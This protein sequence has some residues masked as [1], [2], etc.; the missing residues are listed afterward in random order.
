MQNYPN[1]S[2]LLHDQHDVPIKHD[3][4]CSTCLAFPRLSSS[5][6]RKLISIRAEDAELI[7]GIFRKFQNFYRVKRI[8]KC[9]YFSN[10]YI[11]SVC[12]ARN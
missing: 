8:E 12:P 3:L 6:R 2:G 9:R 11:T 1:V 4:D 7:P 5:R 10:P